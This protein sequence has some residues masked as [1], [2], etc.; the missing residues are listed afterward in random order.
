MKSLQFHNCLLVM[1]TGYGL[2]Q[3]G[4]KTALLWCLF[5]NIKSSS[6]RSLRGWL[7]YWWRK[8]SCASSWQDWVRWVVPLQ[9]VATSVEKCRHWVSVE[10]FPWHGPANGQFRGRKY[11]NSWGGNS[12]WAMKAKGSILGREISKMSNSLKNFSFNYLFTLSTFTE[13]HRL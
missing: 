12:A 4:W 7:N 1:N 11:I 13:A 10:V 3:W 9:F 2:C 5:Q 8:T 6:F